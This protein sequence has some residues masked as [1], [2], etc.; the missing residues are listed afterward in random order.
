MDFVTALLGDLPIVFLLLGI[1]FCLMGFFSLFVWSWA[2]IRGRSEK[3]RVI[4]GIVYAYTK[5]KH[6]DGKIVEKPKTMYCTVFEYPDVN[7]KPKKTVRNTGSATFKYRTDQEI[8]LL[9]LPNKVFDDVYDR[10]DHTPLI[11]GVCFLLLGTGIV[12]V[13][14][15]LMKALGVS[16]LSLCLSLIILIIKIVAEHRGRPGSKLNRLQDHELDAATAIPIEQMKR[17]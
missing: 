10:S 4:G 9:I 11:A 1:I 16:L 6:R 15:D 8:D 2:R 14:G 12:F 7:G 5:Q 17:T 13:V 3:G